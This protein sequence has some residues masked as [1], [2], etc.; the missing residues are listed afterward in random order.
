[1][2]PGR[3]G[4]S[5]KVAEGSTQEALQGTFNEISFCRRIVK[6]LQKGRS[7]LDFRLSIMN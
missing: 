7:K 3:V 1:M 2:V 4:I 5:S 6:C